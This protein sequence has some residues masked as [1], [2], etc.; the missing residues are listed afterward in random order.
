KRF[1]A[2]IS[3]SSSNSDWVLDNLIHKLESPFDSHDAL[4][5]CIHKRDFVGGKSILLNIIDSI[6][7][8]HHT[9]VVLSRQ[10]IQSVWSMTEFKEAYEESVTKKRRHLII[11][12][13]EDIQETEMDS[14]LKRCIKTFTYIDAKDPKF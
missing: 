4:S 7:N 1:D 6:E 2:F 9:I 3:Y 10:F 14:M 13:Y 5:L 8:S 11:I 12:K